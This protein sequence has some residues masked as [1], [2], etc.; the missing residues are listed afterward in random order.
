MDYL[1]ILAP[2]FVIHLLNIN[3][4]LKQEQ[5]QESDYI[6][7]IYNFDN[8]IEDILGLVEE[9]LVIQSLNLMLKLAS[10]E[11]PLLHVHMYIQIYFCNILFGNTNIKYYIL[12]RVAF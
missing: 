12:C 11:Y 4:D 6:L 7:D 2:N 10:Y 3:L 9:L 1:E 5:I 8:Y